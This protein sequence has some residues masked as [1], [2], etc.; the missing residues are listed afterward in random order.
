MTSHLKCYLELARSGIVND[1]KYDNPFITLTTVCNAFRG[2]ILLDGIFHIFLMTLEEHYNRICEI[3]I[4]TMTNSRWGRFA[5]AMQKPLPE[6]TRL[7]LS[8]DNDVV[9]VLP[10]SFLGG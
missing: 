4:F 10:D 6:L 9:P 2:F 5:A 3:T 7:E 1:L 8:V